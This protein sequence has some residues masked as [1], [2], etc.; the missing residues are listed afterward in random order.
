MAAWSYRARSLFVLLVLTVSESYLLFPK[1]DSA[2]VL[3][4]VLESANGTRSAVRELSVEIHGQNFANGMMIKLTGS[5]SSCD[6]DTRFRIKEKH[7][8][9]SKNLR[10][11]VLLPADHADIIYFCVQ[12]RPDAL[13]F[14]GGSEIIKWNHAGKS[15]FIKLSPRTDS[16]SEQPTLKA[17]KTENL[18]RANQ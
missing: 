9:F 1:L 15:V 8:E 4:D 18:L 12:Q 5:E 6:D 2:F 13:N 16:A 7:V 10:I 17:A 14:G 11:K 3:N